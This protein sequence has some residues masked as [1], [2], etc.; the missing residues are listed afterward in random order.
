MA[1]R[2]QSAINSQCEQ[3]LYESSGS[4]TDL[5]NPQLSRI[6]ISYRPDS[7]S[8]DIQSVNTNGDYLGKRL[9][10]ADAKYI[11]SKFQWNIQSLANNIVTRRWPNRN[12]ADGFSEELFILEPSPSKSKT[13][14]L[15]ADAN[16]K[17][18]N[19][20][21][22]P[23]AQQSERV[24]VKRADL[25]RRLK[26][27]NLGS[28]RQAVGLKDIFFGSAIQA[29]AERMK[30][31]TKVAH[32][33]L[34]GR[35]VDNYSPQKEVADEPE[36]NKDDAVE[37]A[38]QQA[39]NTVKSQKGAH[40]KLQHRRPSD[41]SQK[42][43]GS[44]QRATKRQEVEKTFSTRS[45]RKSSEQNQNSRKSLREPA[46]QPPVAQVSASLRQSPQIEQEQEPSAS[47]SNLNVD[48]S[49][50]SHHV[51]KHSSQASI[52][53]PKHAIN[54]E[55][56]DHEASIQDLQYAVENFDNIQKVNEAVEAREEERKEEKAVEQSYEQALQKDAQVANLLNDGQSSGSY[57]DKFDEEVAE[58]RKAVIGAKR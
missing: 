34:S 43:A 51:D 10:K 22:Y 33:C 19:T 49:R 47:K 14:K 28:P 31:A 29:E 52:R 15:P 8:V 4:A 24:L 17:D 18:A 12:Q 7:Q 6:I 37:A 20:S 1:M 25:P 38:D 48:N 21:T 56:V 57:E 46:T 41:Q 30:K 50:Q 5:Q 13:L 45:A 9:A 32:T 58:T 40:D 3:I 36:G 39:T 55:S 44:E 16:P 2:L 23:G 53:K 42:E 35:S 54:F 27:G 11:F 26:Y